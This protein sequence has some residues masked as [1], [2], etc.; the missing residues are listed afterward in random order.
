MKTSTAGTDLIKEFEGLRLKA[1]KCPAD[2]WTIG[3]GHTSAAGNPI[4]TS[5]M[6]ITKEEADEILQDDLVQYE[7]AVNDLVKVPLTQNQFD[8]LVS[9]AYNAGVGALSKST[10]LKR[11]NAGQFD[12]VP[13]EFMKWTKGGGKELPGLVRRRRAEVALWR[14]MDDAAPVQVE[15]ASSQPDLPT[16][17]KK[18]TQ[19][20]EANAAILTGI[21][22]A[23][24]AADQIIPAIKQGHDLFNSLTPTAMICV[25]IVLIAI[26]I[27]WFR[28]QRLDEDG[29]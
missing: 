21:A 11:V 19:S 5:G 25:V 4:V 26:A 15:E 12:Q 23:S 13:A 22:G 28:K 14:G 3:Y 8:A 2:V 18:I 17:K 16:P 1:Y 24:A 29:A 9:F 10:L 6:T 20:R 27:W 7:K